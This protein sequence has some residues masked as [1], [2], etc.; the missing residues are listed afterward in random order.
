MTHGAV[1]KRIP[2][3]VIILDYNRAACVENTYKA[4]VSNNSCQACPANSESRGEGNA[5]CDCIPPNT[6]N[7]ANPDDPCTS[8]W[9]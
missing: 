6:R 9:L 7:P 3:N 2:S 4:G 5:I 8:K 1:C